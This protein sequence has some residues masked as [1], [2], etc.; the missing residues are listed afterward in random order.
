MSAS[1][2]RAGSLGPCDD[3][4][5]DDGDRTT[6]RNGPWI[7]HS[8]RIAYENP[9]ITVWHDEVSRPDGSPG[10]YG[11][12]HFANLAAGVVAIDN[13][14]R[15]LLVGQHRYA[16]D[17]QS[18][19]IPEGGVSPDETPLDG[20]RREL[21]EEAGVEATDW[22]EIGR[23]HLSNSVSDETGIMYLARGLTY[24][25]PRPDATEQIEVRWV[26]FDEALTMT[27]DGRIT[28]AMSIMGIQRVALER[29]GAADGGPDALAPSAPANRA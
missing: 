22:R 17:Q 23:F 3:W 10:V 19:E 7:R 24:G 26:S 20:M 25:V 16:L 4:P 21:V 5:M 15:V 9:W 12:V 27:L 2:T 8:R 18:W 13:D 11:V 1:A 29:L 6:T 14:D 28:D